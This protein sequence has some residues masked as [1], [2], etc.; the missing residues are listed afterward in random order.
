MRI[1]SSDPHLCCLCFCFCCLQCVYGC[2]VCLMLPDLFCV[3][4][5]V[6]WF[7]TTFPVSALASLL[8]LH[9]QHQAT[10][11]GA[12]FALI[13][14]AAATVWNIGVL[15]LAYTSILSGNMFVAHPKAAP[16]LLPGV[17]SLAINRAAQF[18]WLLCAI[19]LLVALLVTVDY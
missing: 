15:L 18:S 8:V 2:S 7:S 12:I 9:Q 10:R 3:G 4:F 17:T 19:G 6:K 1:H 14:L 16:H 5:S 11:V 13:A